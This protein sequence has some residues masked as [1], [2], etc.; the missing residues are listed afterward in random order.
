MPT[1][2][3]RF[4]GKAASLRHAESLQTA[5]NSSK[6]CALAPLEC[7]HTY[8]Y[9]C[10]QYKK[11]QLVVW[12]A[13]LFITCPA[14]LKAAFSALIAVSNCKKPEESDFAAVLV[15]CAVVCYVSLQLLI[16]TACIAWACW[17]VECGYLT[18]TN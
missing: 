17:Y 15:S 13:S 9:S 14:P 4:Y 11:K 7:Q 10:M 5:S 1:K 2:S 8:N 16:Y 12:C 3:H 6:I 18:T